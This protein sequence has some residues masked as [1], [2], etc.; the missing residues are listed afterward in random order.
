MSKKQTDLVRYFLKTSPLARFQ[1]YSSITGCSFYKYPDPI[2]KSD[3]E[4]L[5]GFLNGLEISGPSV[6]MFTSMKSK[7]VRENPHLR[8]IFPTMLVAKMQTAGN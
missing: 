2:I 8:K 6:A 1:A 5:A 3:E 4:Y 7:N